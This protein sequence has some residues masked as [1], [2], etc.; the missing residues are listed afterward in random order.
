MVCGILRSVGDT[1]FGLYMDV[2]TMWGCSILL[3]GA[4]A[5][6]F[7]AGVPAVYAI[8]MS[9]EIIKVPIC[10]WRYRKYKWLRNVTREK[11]E[12]R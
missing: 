3:G 8:L 11:E 1:K 12:L 4:A 9:D 7:H 5:F 10:I 2:T 6:V